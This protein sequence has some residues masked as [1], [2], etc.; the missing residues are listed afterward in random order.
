MRPVIIGVTGGFGTGKSTVAAMFRKKG[1]TLLDADKIAHNSILPGRPCYKKVLSLF[2]SDILGRG[3]RIDRKKLGK[4]VF[5]DKKKLNL[6]NSV[7]HPEVI[8]EI[9]EEVKKKSSRRRFYVVDVPL[10]IESG[11]S[12]SVDELVVVVARAVGHED[13]EPFPHG[14]SGSNDEDVL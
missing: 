2:G 7:I 10:L 8:K 11:F 13:F 3:G 12:K 1:A 9:R 6:L 4:I 5:A 14:Q